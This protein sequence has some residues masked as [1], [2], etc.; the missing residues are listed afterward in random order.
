M[1]RCEFCQGK[2]SAWICVARAPSRRNRD[3]LSAARRR[4]R[5]FSHRICGVFGSSCQFAQRARKPF[6]LANSVSPSRALDRSARHRWSGSWPTKLSASS[7]SSRNSPIRLLQA[8]SSEGSG[9]KPESYRS[10]PGVDR[11]GVDHLGDDHGNFTWR[12][13]H[14]PVR[15]NAG[16][17]SSKQ[18]LD[19]QRVTMWFNVKSSRQKTKR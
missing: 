18:G 3:E 13:A 14:S 9:M 2:R 4:P 16:F 8:H 1:L 17:A 11:T 12:G 6:S 7:P 10:R 5:R 15:E 19:R